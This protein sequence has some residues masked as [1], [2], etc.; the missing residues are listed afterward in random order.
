MIVAPQSMTHDKKV[1]VLDIFL[2][3][4]QKMMDK[5]KENRNDNE[6]QHETAIG[7]KVKIE[8]R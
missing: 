5:T 1:K 4:N 6:G 3:D 8:T 2:L 7:E